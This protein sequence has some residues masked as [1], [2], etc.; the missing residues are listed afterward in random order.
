MPTVYHADD[1]ND[2]TYLDKTYLV[3]PSGGSWSQSIFDGTEIGMYT[4]DTGKDLWFYGALASV[5][6]LVAGEEP[7]VYDSIFM[8]CNF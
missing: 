1:P 3:P 2:P 6:Y 5:V 8:G 4:N 7:S